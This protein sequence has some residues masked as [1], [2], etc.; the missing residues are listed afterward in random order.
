[1]HV[2][3]IF[4]VFIAT[5]KHTI[6]VKTV[7]FYIISRTA[8]CFDISMSSSGSF[9]FVPCQVTQIIKIE[10][11]KKSQFLKIIKIY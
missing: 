5:N 4:I 9:T 6:N 11:A 3:C 8:T 1:M 7:S 2:L 10:A